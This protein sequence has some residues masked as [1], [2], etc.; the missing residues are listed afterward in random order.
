M[1]KIMEQFH[2]DSALLKANRI[3]YQCWN[4]HKESFDMKTK[5]DNQT[6]ESRDNMAILQETVTAR[7]RE[8]VNELYWNLTRDYLGYGCD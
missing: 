1:F 4:I 5:N 7:L 3:V 8:V 2:E 6:K